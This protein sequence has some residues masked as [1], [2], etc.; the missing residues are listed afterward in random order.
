MCSVCVY[1]NIIKLSSLILFNFNL[2]ALVRKRE[3]QIHV[4]V[5][6]YNKYRLLNEK[7]LINK[8]NLFQKRI[9]NTS[10]TTKTHTGRPMVSMRPRTCFKLFNLVKTCGILF[11]LKVLNVNKK[12]LQKFYKN[13]QKFTKTKGVII[14][15]RI[16]KNIYKKCSL[17]FGKQINGYQLT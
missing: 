15:L 7:Q 12:R 8:E 1:K 5:I 14:N 4:Y 17:L 2:N 10:F 11:S 3:T 13:N 16:I 9:I 6:N